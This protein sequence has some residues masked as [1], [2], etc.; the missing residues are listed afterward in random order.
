MD[1]TVEHLW[2]LA[3]EAK[4]QSIAA[5]FLA[6]DNRFDNFCFS[7]SNLAADFSKQNIDTRVLD[8]LLSWAEQRK[9]DDKMSAMFSGKKINGTEGRAVLHTVLRAPHGKQ[10]AVL[11]DVLAEDVEKTDQRMMKL[12]NSLYA[13]LHQGASGKAITDVIAV[14]IGGSYYGPKLCHEALKPYHSQAVKVHYLANVDGSALA[15]K[16]QS[17]NPETTLVIVISKTFGTQETLLN[18]QA[19]KK[20]FI[21][22]GISEAELSDHLIAVTSNTEKAQAFGVAAHHI[23]PMWDWVG[24]RFSLWSAVGLPVAIAVGFENYRQLR[25]GAYAIDEHFQTTPFNQNI[26][27]LMAL[28]GIWNCSFLKYSALAV[29][30]YDHSLRVLPGYLQQ[31]DMES[32]GKQVNVF[33]QKVSLSTA[34]IVFGQEGS[35]GQHAFMQ[36]MHQSDTIVPIDF[37]VPLKSHSAYDA[38]H[39]V[40]V[41]NCFAQGEALMKGKPLAQ[42]EAEL[43]EEGK[44]PAQVKALAAHK[45]MP[46]NNPST[47]I[48]F[49]QLT[50]QVLGSLLAL[51]EH[52]I[53]VQ[54][55]M[56]ELNS[57]DQW[58]VELG[59]KLGSTVLDLMAG[60]TNEKLSS[61]SIGLID[62]FKSA[63]EQ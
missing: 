58:G 34:P 59:K 13:G 23:L 62:L 6:D 15:E 31:L 57:F 20:W 37:I 47:T 29:L 39:Q 24:G 18:A 35:N 50:P 60:N 42:A 19:L 43:V 56:W 17:L 30:P 61:S 25:A 32:N 11:G 4:Y 12:A 5:R 51:Y 3:D 54:G 52:K 41:A 53:F 36:L 55:V 48:V 2:A 16:I 27:V 14:G 1:N 33:G 9:L 46:G 45:V 26:P 10:K 7:T 63:H 21:N 38:H 49:D 40:L 8:A 28:F 22:S 44:S